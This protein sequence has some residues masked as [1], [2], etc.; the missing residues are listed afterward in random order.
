MKDKSSKGIAAS[1]RLY[2]RRWRLG[3]LK[4]K[5]NVHTVALLRTFL[6]QIVHVFTSITKISALV[7]F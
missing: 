6:H 1:C 2:K 3:M 4:L 5:Y 7:V